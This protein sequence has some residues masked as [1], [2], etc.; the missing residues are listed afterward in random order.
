MET[1]KI[2]NLG[3]RKLIQVYLGLQQLS[4][5]FTDTLSSEKKSLIG[6]TR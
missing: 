3:S 5:Y 4:L 1:L 6:V 2:A